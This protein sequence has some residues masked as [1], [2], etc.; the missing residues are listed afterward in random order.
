M[1]NCMK[2]MCEC[3]L[4]LPSYK[5]QK[6]TYCYICNE[7]LCFYCTNKYRCYNCQRIKCCEPLKSCST[8]NCD[9]KLCQDCVKSQLKYQMFYDCYCGYEKCFACIPRPCKYCHKN[10][11]FLMN[12]FYIDELNK[13]LCKDII[14]IIEK[15]I[16]INYL[17]S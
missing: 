2:D 4:M 12:K 13:Y 7:V 1:I 9:K 15:Y 3:G 5:N 6:W 17:A 10:L 14:T 8:N 16:K 11:L